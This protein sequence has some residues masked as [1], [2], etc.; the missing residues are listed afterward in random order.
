MEEAVARGPHSSAM[1]PH[2]MTQ[3]AM[4]VAEKIQDNQAHL[5]I[6]D[7]ICHNPPPNLKISPIAMIPHKSWGFRAILDLSFHLRLS[8]GEHIPSVNETTTLTAPWGAIDQL[9]HALSCIIHAFAEAD[10]DAAIFMA[11]FDIKDS[12]WQLVCATGE[13]WKFAYVLP[14]PHGEPVCLV[15]PDSLQMGWVESPAYFCVASE[16]A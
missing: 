15:V 1:H 3:L 8:M 2:A 5:I 12:F 10:P 16:T 9:G 11:K 4:E 13:E 6:W 14:Q 7:D